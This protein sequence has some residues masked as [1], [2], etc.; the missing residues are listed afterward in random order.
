VPPGS[1]WDVA[2]CVAEL[3][4]SITIYGIGPRQGD[5]CRLSRGADVALPGD[6]GQMTGWS[7]SPLSPRSPSGRSSARAARPLQRCRPRE[8]ARGDQ[9]PSHEFRQARR[10][11][12]RMPGTTQRMW[13]R[14]KYVFPRRVERIG[15]LLPRQPPGPSSQEPIARLRD[16]R[17]PAPPGHSGG[18]LTAAVRHC[19]RQNPREYA[20]V[21]PR[22]GCPHSARLTPR[23][24]RNGPRG[25]ANPM[26]RTRH[27]RRSG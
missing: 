18:R 13:Y 3:D 26:C 22:R 6:P 7:A 10:P 25:P 8:E 1:V 15:R 4:D 27:M 11:G 16:P 20:A 12:G 24:A 2:K 5:S 17:A 23:S 19:L 21:E 14:A 9:E